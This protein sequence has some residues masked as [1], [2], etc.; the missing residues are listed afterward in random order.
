MNENHRRCISVSFRQ[1]DAKLTEIEAILQAVGAASP[2]SAYAQDVGPMTR[3]GVTSYLERI[4]ERMWSAL[5]QLE[6]PPD[7]RHVSAAWTIQVTLIAIMIALTEI[8]PQRMGGYGKLDPDAGIT[9]AGI[10]ADLQ[11]LAN[12]LNAYLRRAQGED[13]SQR[14]ARLETSPANREALSL[15]EGIITRRGLVELRPMLD[16]ILARLESP[17]F[18]IAFFG[19]VS[20]GKSSLLNYLLGSAVLPVGVLPVT[21]VLTRL[22]RGDRPEMLVR[23]EVSQPARLPADRIAEFVTEEGNPGNTRRVAEVEVRWPSPRLAHGVV[24]MDTPGVGSLATFGAA[25]TKAYLPRCDLGVLL[26]DA[27][28]SLDHEDLALLRGFLEAAILATVLISKSD[29]LSADDRRRV[30]DYIRRQVHETLGTEPSVMLVST[31]GSDAALADRWFEEQI[32]PLTGNHREHAE[33]SLRRKIA[34]LG[35]MAASYLS[36]MIERVQATPAQGARFDR[37]K[38]EALLAAAGDR[39]AAMAA[40]LTQPVDA[41]IA[42]QITQLTQQAAEMIVADARTGRAA[43][44]MIVSCTLAAAAATAEEVRGL[45]DET[46]QSLVQTVRSLSRLCGDPESEALK[47]IIPGFT[48]LPRVDETEV[49]EIPDVHYPKV[50]AWWRG[51]GAWWVRR[52]VRERC[53][54][55][56]WSVLSSHRSGLR[57]WMKV[58]LERLTDAF[59]AHAALFRE[60]LASGGDGRADGAT[61][62]DLRAELDS[63]RRLGLPPDRAESGSGDQCSRAATLNPLAISLL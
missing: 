22:R 59:E 51:L 45:L 41:G 30:V 34:N 48:P 27:G 32:V 3:L 43:E 35:E 12:S 15:I 6:I 29:L 39:L 40:R 8:E 24:F 9:L 58:N 38:G 37:A 14:L 26:V 16:A 5:K 13:L 10:C 49:S 42:D 44:R 61:I 53:R 18:E 62:E 31:R 11:R 25:Q 47:E 55:A 33:R 1:I 17:E 63:L 2:F 36:A 52:R 60:R 23:S 19:R 50:L 21:A 56:I 46:A 54:W 4:R 7:Q 28:S 57:N 20:S